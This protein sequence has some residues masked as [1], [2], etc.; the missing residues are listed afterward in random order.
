MRILL[1][2]V[3]VFLLIL[4]GPI[5]IYRAIRHGRYRSDIRQYFGAVPVRYGLQPI[6]WVHGVS[7]GEVNAARTLVQRFHEAL[8]DF[9][10][11]ISSTT[12]T[13][14]A[15][16]R[17]RF[18][19]D[20]VVFRFPK[21]FSFAVR[22]ALRRVRPDLVVLIEGDIWPNFL[23]EANRRDVPVVVVNGRMSPNKGYPRYRKLGPLA[24]KLL[25]NRL[26]AIGVQNETYAECFRSLGTGSEKVHVT[27]ML[28]FD[29]VETLGDGETLPGQ[30]DLAAALG[31]SPS[32]RL[33]VAGGTGPGEEAMLLKIFAGIRRTYPD[34]R[35]VVVPR[36][37]ERFDEVAR[38]IDEAGFAVVRRSCRQDP[39]NPPEG[40]PEI[41]LG[42]TMGELRTF[43][44]LAECVFVGRSL[45][46]MGGSDMIEAA[47]LGRP[48]AFGPHTFNFPQADELAENGAQRVTTAEE[49]AKVLR[50]WL[51]DPE[52]ARRQASGARDYV[53]S[54]QGATERNLDMIC[55][56]LDRCPPVA[57]GAIATDRIRSAG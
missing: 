4:S 16:A 46:P 26:S 25:F 19:H 8:P 21:D 10:V 47:A 35:L 14:I 41:I 2:I 18:G 45:V 53:R 57:P 43:Y 54:R 52:S 29:T 28:K 3:Y 12:D 38:L 37:P 36:K 20:H 32:D 7:V 31:I 51:G 34:A 50:R 40:K 48:V 17:K 9:Q 13:G 5:W 27:G 24:D 56:V 15:A 49:L 22:R 1:D 44:A 33:I 23:A 30:E 42:D 11:M 6:I 39:A 55:E